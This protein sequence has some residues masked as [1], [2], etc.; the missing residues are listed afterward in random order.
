M[1]KLLHEVT[2]RTGEVYQLFAEL[3]PCSTNSKQLSFYGVW[4]GNKHPKSEPTKHEF[5]LGAEAIDNLKQLLES[6]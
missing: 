5:L 3:V 1:K 2:D 4:T 6:V